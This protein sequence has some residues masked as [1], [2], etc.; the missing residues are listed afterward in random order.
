M[1]GDLISFDDLLADTSADGMRSELSSG[2]GGCSSKSC[3]SSAGPGDM[4]ADIW[5]KI[6]DHPCY[7]Y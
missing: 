1:T 6:K 4:P 7:S 2:A 5:A 3:G